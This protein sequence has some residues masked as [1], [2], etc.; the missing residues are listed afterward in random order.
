VPVS[1]FPAARLITHLHASGHIKS[2]YIFSFGLQVVLRGGTGRGRRREFLKPKILSKLHLPT[3]Q[4]FTIACSVNCSE[5]DFSERERAMLTLIASH[6]LNAVRSVYFLR[7]AEQRSARF[8][9]IINGCQTGVVVLSPDGQIQYASE[10][11]RVMLE[12]YFPREV[13]AALPRNCSVPGGSVGSLRRPRN[14]FCRTSF[15]QE[16]E[17]WGAANQFDLQQPDA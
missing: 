4:D 8:G 5:K 11:A 2:R 7:H 15:D 3:A 10:A 9:E 1:E 17:C 14:S 16:N 13:G 6:L 12:K